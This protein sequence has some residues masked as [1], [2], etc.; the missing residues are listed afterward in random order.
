[1][2]PVLG[3]KRAGALPP[4]AEAAQGVRE[5]AVH[6]EGV[7]EPPGAAVAGAEEAVAVAVVAVAVVA[8]AN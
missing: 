7:E 2:L 6:H 3:A 8:V 1:M 4:A 5:A